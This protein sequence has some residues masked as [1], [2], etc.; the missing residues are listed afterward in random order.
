MDLNSRAG[1]IL[2]LGLEKKE[3]SW[4]VYPSPLVSSVEESSSSSSKT[5]FRTCKSNFQVG[6]HVRVL[7]TFFDDLRICF[8]TRKHVNR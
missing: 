6:E 4:G 1:K 8:L 7:T 2:Q 5:R 3:R